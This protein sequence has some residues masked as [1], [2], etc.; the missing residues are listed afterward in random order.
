[1][2]SGSRIDYNC[3]CM[4]EE[5]RLEENESGLAPV[6]DGWFVVNVRDAAWAT[7]ETFG[8]DCIFESPAVEF[9]ELGIR[10]CVLE[11]GQPNGL[12]HGE[13]TQEDFL[14]LA[15]EC[16]LL[17]EGE[18]RRLQAWDFFHCA[19]GTEHIFVGSGESLCVILMTGTRR[20]GRPIY[21]PV[22]D[23][24]LRHKAGVEAETPS[25]KVAYASYPQERVARP[26]CWDELPWA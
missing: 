20:P 13:E 17:V 3:L 25:P 6:T 4:V 19:P 8:A 2:V 9:T 12:Y 16:L 24:A 1:M 10:L 26:A 21:Y 5:A 7:H 18:E 22:S 11:P 14:V 15:G 23:L